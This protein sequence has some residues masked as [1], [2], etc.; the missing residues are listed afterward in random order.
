MF[1]ILLWVFR[2]C[3]FFVLLFLFLKCWQKDD[4]ICYL[5]RKNTSL[6]HNWEI[7]EHSREKWRADFYRLKEK[8]DAIKDTLES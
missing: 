5:M 7:A 2:V 3:L 6:R 8:L 4:E 1:L